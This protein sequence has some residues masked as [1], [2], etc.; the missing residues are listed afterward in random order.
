[1]GNLVEFEKAIEETHGD[2]NHGK[3]YKKWLNNFRKYV[4]SLE[5]SE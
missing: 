1:M 4:E 5:V 3:Q 2:N